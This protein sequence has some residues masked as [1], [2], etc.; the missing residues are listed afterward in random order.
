MAGPVTEG[1]RQRTIAYPENCCEIVCFLGPDGIMDKVNPANY[2]Y[3]PCHRDV[4]ISAM[5]EEGFAGI[6]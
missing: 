2:G 1:I 5:R 4:W 6:L 3:G